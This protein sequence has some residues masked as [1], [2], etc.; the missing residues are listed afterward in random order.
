M[1]FRVAECFFKTRWRN[2]E[3]REKKGK[4]RKKRGNS[5]SDVCGDWEA[6]ERK[7]AFSEAC[8]RLWVCL[9]DCGC[10]CGWLWPLVCPRSAHFT[11]GL[12]KTAVFSS[13][14]IILSKHS[15][16]RWVRPPRSTAATRTRV[17]TPCKTSKQEALDCC[18]AVRFQEQ[19]WPNGKFV[20]KHQI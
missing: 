15:S 10:R 4:R 8:T 1:A 19:I 6:R 9:G 13:K 14:S 11:R 12:L 7:M 5:K 18:D 16:Q 20:K 2:L 17:H 3:R